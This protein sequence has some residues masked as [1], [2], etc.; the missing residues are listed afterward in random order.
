MTWTL[1]AYLAGD[2]SV[3]RAVII[4]SP[5]QEDAKRLS[6]ERTQLAAEKTRHTN[7]IRGLLSLHGI[8]EVKGLWGGAW[9]KALS[10]LRTG[11]G[12]TLGSYLR[13]EIAREF[14]R[15]HLVLQH[16]TALDADRHAA[17]TDETS[18]FPERRKAA[19]LTKLA[20]IGPISATALVAEVFHRRFQNRKHLARTWGLRQPP[21]RAGT[22]SA[23]RASAK[24]AISQ[25]AASS[26]SLPGAGCGTSQAVV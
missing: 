8:R 12:R 4:P 15:L 7:R 19:S 16:M 17:L 23:T 25:L 6:R 10:E 22:T 2:T 14:E 1:K 11:D 26:S 9:A 20:G 18:A 3:C 24:L 13:A 5:E 21:M